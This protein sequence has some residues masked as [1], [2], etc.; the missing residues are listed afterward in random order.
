MHITAT[1]SDG[2]ALPTWLNLHLPVFDP[3][4]SGT[5]PAADVGTLSVKITATNAY[6]SVSDEFDI[7]VRA[8]GGNNAPMVANAI[9]DQYATVSTAFRYAFPTNTFNDA[10]RGDTLT[11]T[12]TKSDGAVLPTWLDFNDSTRTFS[13]MPATA[14]TV[15]VK[16]TASDGNGGSVSNEFS[17]VVRTVALGHCRSLDPLELWCASLTVGT[18]TVSGSN[19]YGYFDLATDIGALSDTQF[20]YESVTYTVNYIYVEGTSLTLALIPT[21]G[22][23]FTGNARLTLRIGTTDFSFGSMGFS[24]S[25]F[26]YNETGPRLV[27]WRHG[28]AQAP[29]EPRPRPPT[30]R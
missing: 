30:R 20:T 14:G 4:F 24:T 22:S 3:I 7:E 12:A 9:P 1:K 25:E 16:V 5:P 10:D 15:A 18:R 2:N 8:A 27:G 23:V 11:Y 28:R 6:G 17:I 26:I 13:G 19:F 29:P 21:G